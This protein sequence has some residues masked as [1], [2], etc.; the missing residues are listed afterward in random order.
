MDIF[1]PLGSGNGRGIVEVVSGAWHSDRGKLRDLSKARVFDIL[2]RRGYTV[3]AVRPGSVSKFSVPE[4]VAHL[5]SG[6]RWVKEH[7]SDYE[8]D[9]DALGLM[10]ASAGG[11]LACLVAVGN[12]RAADDVDASVAAAGVFFPPTDFLDYG[13]RSLDPRTD[14]RLGEMIR[15]LAFPDGIDGLDDAQIHERV[16][17]ISPARRVTEDT[18][19]FL[20]IHGDADFVVPIQQSQTMVAALERKG[21]PVRLIVKKG[22][23]HPWPTVHEEVAVL[24]DWFD[25]Q[26]AVAAE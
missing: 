3:F 25:A 13:G 8:I 16:T 21:V 22:G 23:G 7:A 2:C 19:P 4:M 9:A 24:A 17:D 12:G 11:H 20:L 10:G 26:L 1:T 6:I 15:R 14:D 18:P 5:E